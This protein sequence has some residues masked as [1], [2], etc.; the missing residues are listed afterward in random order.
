MEYGVVN[1]DRQTVSIP[2]A[3][4][5]RGFWLYVW[6]VTTS[7]GQKLHYVG[8]TGDNSSLNAQ[9]PFARMSAHL[10]SN[11]MSNTLRGHL[12][13]KRIKPDSCRSLKLVAY[14][15]IYAEAND[16][17][18]HVERRDKV[19][20]IEK[21]LCVAMIAGGYTVLNDVKS[22]KELD[23]QKWKQVRGAFLEDFPRLPSH[24]DALS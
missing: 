24:P 13:R 8:R 21:A 19:A 15:P 6:E 14:G 7:S 9:S 3:A 18:N 2:G 20:G 11:K 5:T 10:G 1:A 12:E 16:R 22:R 4:L 23:C 17:R